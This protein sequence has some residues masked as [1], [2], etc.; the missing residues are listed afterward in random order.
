MTALVSTSFIV[1][2][3]MGNEAAQE[4]LASFKVGYKYAAVSFLVYVLFQAPILKHYST[5]FKEK[6]LS[7][8][9][10]RKKAKNCKEML[11]L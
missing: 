9:P 3:N 2:S 11:S 7:F 10:G 1:T 5:Q 4:A 8:I 6:M